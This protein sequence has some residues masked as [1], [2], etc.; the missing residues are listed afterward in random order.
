[1]QLMLLSSLL[2]DPTPRGRAAYNA[3]A[4]GQVDDFRDFIRLHY[5]SERRDS[6][7]WQDVAASHP[8][9]VTDKLALWAGRVPG[10][11]DFKP[12]A[13]GL[14]HIGHELHVP[15]LDGL[16]LLDPATAREW[17]AARPD[18]RSL[19]RKSVE[20]LR[21]DY[22]QAANRCLGHRAFLS[23]LQLETAS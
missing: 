9:A 12:F 16:G 5:V 8:A 14:P 13:M 1:M 20:T 11:Q 10:P 15:V 23:S 3:A 21:K 6:A 18:L 17:L 22:L 4:A 7:F 19:A 2:P